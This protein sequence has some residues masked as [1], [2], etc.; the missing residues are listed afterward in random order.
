MEITKSQR[1]VLANFVGYST[2]SKLEEWR[3]KF[4]WGGEVVGSRPVTIGPVYD[5]VLKLGLIEYIHG[6]HQGYGG[7]YRKSPLLDVFKCDYKSNDRACWEG[8]I[9]IPSDSNPDE[10]VKT[11]CPKCDGTGLLL[12][13]KD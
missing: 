5:S 8:E 6:H 7:I 13:S 10:G 2:Y 4:Y 12:K 3:G 1:K 11:K 9:F